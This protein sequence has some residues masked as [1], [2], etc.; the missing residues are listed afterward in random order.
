MSDAFEGSLH[1]LGIAHSVRRNE[2]FTA[3]TYMDW[4]DTTATFDVQ[5]ARIAGSIPSAVAESV[6][7][8]RDFTLFQNHPNPFNP[9]T[10]IRY[11]MSR[12]ERIRISVHDLRGRLVK[13]LVDQVQAP[14]IH[15]VSWNGTDRS[16]RDVSTGIYFYSIRSGGQVLTRKMTLAR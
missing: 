10:E 1:I 15:T 7:P 11:R 5:G 9:E 13:I 3:Y 4:S 14:G 6:R 2:F 12:Q 8:P 16:G